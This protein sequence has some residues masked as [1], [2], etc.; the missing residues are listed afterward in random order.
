MPE[1]LQIRWRS[2]QLASAHVILVGSILASSPD[3]RFIVGVEPGGDTIRF[4]DNNGFSS[5]ALDIL[6]EEETNTTI[7]GLTGLFRAD[8][9]AIGSTGRPDRIGIAVERV[10]TGSSE[11]QRAYG[12]IVD[13]DPALR[14]G[15]RIVARP[16]ISALEA[17][18]ISSLPLLEQRRVA[19]YP[20]GIF[21]LHD[22]L[23][24]EGLGLVAH[25]T[26]VQ[27][28]NPDVD[29]VRN[30]IV[31]WTFDGEPNRLVEP[32]IML[33]IG[34]N[35]HAGPPAIR[36]DQRGHILSLSTSAYGFD[37]P[38]TNA[39]QPLSSRTG[40][41]PAMHLRYDDRATVFSGITTPVSDSSLVSRS[42]FEQLTVD[43]VGGAT[44]DNYRLYFERRESRPTL[45]PLFHLT[46]DSLA[47]AGGQIFRDSSLAT[48]EGFEIIPVDLD[49]KDSGS[50]EGEIALVN[51]PGPELLV[52]RRTSGDEIRLFLYRF[53]RKY[54]IG[55]T[56]L[57]Y[58]SSWQ[59]RGR[60]AVAG[61]LVEDGADREEFVL[62]RR[63]SL[64]VL[65]L[66][67]YEERDLIRPFDELTARPFRTFA[68][69]GLAD[70]IITAIIAD[71]DLDGKNDIVAVTGEG[72]YLI[73]ATE[74]RPFTITRQPLP[75]YCPSDTLDVS[76]RR[77][78]IGGGKT[79]TEGV[80][81]SILGP[82]PDDERP[83]AQGLIGADRVRFRP[84]EIPLDA[85]GDFRIRVYD[86]RLPHLSD[87]SEA[88]RIR[89]ASIGELTFGQPG[90]VR[91]GTILYDTVAVECADDLRLQ[92]RDA[93]GD[94]IPIPG[95]EGSVSTIDDRAYVRLDVLC[96]SPID[97][98][99]LG[100]A[101][102]TEYRLRSRSDSGEPFVLRVLPRKTG[103]TVTPLGSPG[104]RR[105]TATWDAG[106]LGCLQPVVE[107][108]DPR[109]GR[110]LPLPESAIF[111]GRAEI[112]V[113]PD[114][115]DSI[116]LCLL[117]A[118][119]CVGATA[120]FDVGEVE[121]DNYIAPNPFDPDGVDASDGATIVVWLSSNADAVEIRI[122]DAARSR[123]R[124]L[125]T[126]TARSGRFSIGWDG[127]NESGEIVE[128]GTYVCVILIDSHEPL[129]IPFVVT[130]R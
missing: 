122:V 84:E 20:I 113:P 79:G 72:T 98:S 32:D 115:S 51:N 27:S 52:E 103:V 44:S 65:G 59:T 71:V 36:R 64:F 66:R 43:A 54:P 60:I 62:L 130:D 2:E 77:N 50:T 8:T 14:T 70:S 109:L 105:Y 37:Y 121:M 12:L 48:A 4:L 129:Y 40:R 81:V 99:S 102:T 25:R 97:C 3:E 53:N 10:V 57:G 126:H 120:R 110:R 104:E 68:R 67:P 112:V 88:F 55:T 31:H 47:G 78:T 49:G 15:E 119:R 13:P 56:A 107:I 82:G 61:D 74:T 83:L 29:S 16:G 35:P 21:K 19:V 30:G 58:F 28:G 87:T 23:S 26:F 39:T 5:V 95:D 75:D 111:A 80:G 22:T 106:D 114:F 89:S 6:P 128:N 92:R 17:T 101:M 96:T 46:F 45:G 91:P 11:S 24:S 117:C 69:F 94:W 73:G 100:S 33:R 108:T 63:D 124:D 93:D 41:A 7:L 127:T 86:L 76:W 1:D 125:G 42:R 34:P 85:S 90:N 118:D 9:R 18:R 116:D 123:V 38:I